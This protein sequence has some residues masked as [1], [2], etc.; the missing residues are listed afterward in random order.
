MEDWV[1]L[2]S[3]SVAV[4]VLRAGSPLGPLLDGDAPAAVRLRPDVAGARHGAEGVVVAARAAAVRPQRAFAAEQHLELLLADL[5]P[6]ASP[7]RTRN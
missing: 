7:L 4:V 6:P 3:N 5:V 2:A 1:R